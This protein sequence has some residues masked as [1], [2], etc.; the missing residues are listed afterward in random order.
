MANSISDFHHT[1]SS[2]FYS[3]WQAHKLLPAYKNMIR[4]YGVMTNIQCSHYEEEENS[5]FG[6]QT[7]HQK[8]S[9]KIKLRHIG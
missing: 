1:N 9:T 6:K 8:T 3:G 4:K 7:F 5:L 2:I